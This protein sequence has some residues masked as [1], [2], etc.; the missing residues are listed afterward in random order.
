MFRQFELNC[1]LTTEV[2]MDFASVVKVSEIEVL[3]VVI[4]AGSYEV[5]STTWVPLVTATISMTV[6]VILVVNAVAVEVV[7]WLRI[8]VKVGVVMDKHEQAFTEDANAA[9]KGGGAAFYVLPVMEIALPPRHVP[10][11]FYWHSA[12]VWRYG[13]RRDWNWSYSTDRYHKNRDDLSRH[14]CWKR[15]Y[16][17]WYSK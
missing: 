14:N 17:G 5:K 15:G 1:M 7:V 9:T 8:E 2:D 13:R 11:S 10:Q 12:M 16:C 3:V 6:V 4:V